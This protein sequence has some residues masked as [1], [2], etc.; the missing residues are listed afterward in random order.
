VQGQT[1][2]SKRMNSAVLLALILFVLSGTKLETISALAL[3]A[4]LTG[5]NVGGAI[6]TNTTWTVIG[7]PYIV[8]ENVV[9]LANVFLT[10]EP[11]VTVKFGNGTSIIVD[12]TL[13]AEGSP[14]GI[15][16]FT[17]NASSPAADDWGSIGTR[18]G[19]RIAE[20]EWTM[21]EYSTDGIEFP[22]NPSSAISACAFRKNGVGVS[23]SNVSVANCTF[24]NNG[25]GVNAANV[26]IID[27]E[28]SNNTNAIVG[29]GTCAVQNTKVWDNSGNGILVNGT[30]TN[31][32]VYDNG[33]YGGSS[34]FYG[35]YSYSVIYESF[36]RPA[37]SFI[38]CSI[39]GNEGYGVLAA[40]II[41]CS[42]YDNKGYGVAGSAINCL[43]FNNSGVGIR[44]NA[45]SCL[46]FKNGGSGIVGSCTNCTI[47][48]NGK[49]G[50]NDPSGWDTPSVVNCRI[51]NNN[52]T[53][54]NV[55]GW[56]T[57]TN[58]LDSA[59]F[60]NEGFGLCLGGYESLVS[61][62]D[63]YDNLA[64]GIVVPTVFLGYNVPL[65]SSWI[66]NS[67][68]H[69]N[70]FGILESCIGNQGSED[71]RDL[72][73]SG[74]NI[75]HNVENG[76]VT[77]AGALYLGTIR[78]AV[79]DTIIDS[80]GRFG[81]SLNTTNQA[82]GLSISLPILEVT[83][84][85]ITNQTVGL[86]GSIGNVAACVIANNSEAGLDVFQVLGSQSIWYGSGWIDITGIHQNN[87]YDNGFYNIKSQIPFGQDLNATLNW[88]GTTNTTEI[89]AS[90]YDYY[91]DYNLSRVLF[92]PILTSQ[93]PEFPS[94]IILA[95]FMIA[96]LLTAALL[97]RKNMGRS[98]LQKQ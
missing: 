71:R 93:I 58:I 24:Q 76:I 44:G 39:Y 36:G 10:I 77:E 53:G 56:P 52:G 89:G 38:N 11:G 72:L 75:S 5:T 30:V 98:R 94:P 96:S 46:V 28:F 86:V 45:T 62:C 2:L 33:G 60:N 63:I 8:S 26:S 35:S 92:E 29:S 54:V 88:W 68:I 82:N 57:G 34:I 87:I 97:R 43:V 67:R 22:T 61:N 4:A 19:G 3:D 84:C 27:S 81:I 6:T 78:L 47:H 32:S 48:D 37:S 90:I 40:S 1:R 42:V 55:S 20:V 83:N 73:V 95:L 85:I 49:D 16:T 7:S 23:G 13:V 41:N 15:I 31:C 50:V 65:A 25:D 17:S 9:V 91:N 14:S 64:G 69:G 79:K 70:L 12:G 51:Y 80:N 74:C 59:I 18:T 66:E 21:V